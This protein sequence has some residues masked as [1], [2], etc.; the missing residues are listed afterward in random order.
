VYQMSGA[1]VI[2]REGI[3]RFVHRNQHPADHPAD[4]RIWACLDALG[5]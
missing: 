4:E 2:D 1:F 5:A 3:V